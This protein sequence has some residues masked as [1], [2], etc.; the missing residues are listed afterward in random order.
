MSFTTPKSPGFCEWWFNG[1][2]GPE[3]SNAMSGALMSLV[4]LCVLWRNR[5]RGARDTLED[6]VY[7][8]LF[9]NGVASATF[10]Y[11]LYALPGSLDTLTMVNT[12]YGL[13]LVILRVNASLSPDLSPV[14]IMVRFFLRAPHCSM[15]T[16]WKVWQHRNTRCA[17]GSNDSKQMGQ[18]IFSLEVMIQLQLSVK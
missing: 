2:T 10:H 12:T 15:Q 16:G 14:V 13:L 17:S 11:T 6:M 8:F 18:L 1:G 5:S 4:I 3:Y 7:F 9:W